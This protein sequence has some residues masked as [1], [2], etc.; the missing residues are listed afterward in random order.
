MFCLVSDCFVESYSLIQSITHFIDM[1]GGIVSD[2]SSFGRVFRHQTM[3]PKIKREV[4]CTTN[5][6]WESNIFKSSLIIGLS[7]FL[8]SWFYSLSSQN[9]RRRY[10]FHVL[11]MVFFKEIIIYI[12]IYIYIY[13]WGSFKRFISL[14]QIS[15][16]SHTSH[17]CI[18]LTGTEIKNLN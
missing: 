18:G 17:S 1:L 13:I 6:W 16:L 3:S 12:Y 10:I 11:V 4:Q 7:I 5:V 14:T 2:V 9:L 15:D 8:S